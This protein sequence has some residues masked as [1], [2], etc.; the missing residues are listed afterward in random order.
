ME[1]IEILGRIW[2]PDSKDEILKLDE[3]ERA[4]RMMYVISVDGEKY[5]GIDANKYPDCEKPLLSYELFEI[6]DGWDW[7][8]E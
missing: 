1:E 7:Y 8:N 5:A 6:S 2:R 3:N 4:E